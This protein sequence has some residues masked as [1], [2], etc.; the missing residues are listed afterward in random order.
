MR[1]VEGRLLKNLHL[2]RQ[3]GEW[4]ESAALL[5]LSLLSWPLYF[6][7]SALMLQVMSST[8]PISVV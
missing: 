5:G 3:H 6:V 2:V 7:C 4:A 1:E 8:S